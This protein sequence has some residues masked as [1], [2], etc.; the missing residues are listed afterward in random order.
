MHIS[1]AISFSLNSILSFTLNNLNKNIEYKSLKLV[2]KISSRHP[3]YNVRSNFKIFPM[4]QNIL[5]TYIRV[6]VSCVSLSLK[7][8]QF[9]QKSIY[10]LISQ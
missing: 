8:Y 4:I 10:K 3:I 9:P 2:T 7:K 1:L 6:L 5:G